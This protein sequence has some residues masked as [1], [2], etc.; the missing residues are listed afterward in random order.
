M[1]AQS[2]SYPGVSCFRCAETIPVS[3]KVTSLQDEI[4]KGET[5]VA[6]TFVARCKVCCYETVY[7]VKDVHE[8]EG[9]PPKR[10]R[11]AKAA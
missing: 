4:A 7:E 6:Y 3:E 1:L 2:K 8:F 11:M 9:E 10:K 5:N